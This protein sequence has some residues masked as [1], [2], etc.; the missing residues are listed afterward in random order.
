[1]RALVLAP[2][3][4]RDRPLLAAPGHRPRRLHDAA[5]DRE[6]VKTADIVFVGTVTETST[7]I[8]GP[9][10]RSRRSGVAPTSH[11][12]SWSRAARRGTPRPRSI[13]PSR[14]ACA[15]SS[16]RTG[17]TEPLPEV[18]R[19]LADNSCTTTTSWTAD[20]DGRFDRP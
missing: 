1:M 6:A 8:A 14:S 13:G 19:G 9:T 20:L 12:R 17:D 11:A 15:T 2:V 7:A 3:D 10:C 18:A 4:G 16:S 5:T